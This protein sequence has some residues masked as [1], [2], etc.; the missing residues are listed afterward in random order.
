MSGIIIFIII[1]IIIIIISSSSSSSIDSVTS[2]AI[3]YETFIYALT[4]FSYQ[5]KKFTFNW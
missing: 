5:V 1:I 4:Y 3:E 2:I